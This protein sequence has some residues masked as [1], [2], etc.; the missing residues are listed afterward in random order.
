MRDELQEIFRRQDPGRPLAEALDRYMLR[1]R[2]VAACVKAVSRGYFVLWDERRPPHAKHWKTYTRS[3]QATVVL[4]PDG[5][6]RVAEAFANDN[7]DGTYVHYFEN[8][9]LE[10]LVLWLIDSKRIKNFDDPPESQS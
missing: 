7:G 9:T 3:V 4:A 5:Q 6:L 1:R 8:W 2:N 10:D